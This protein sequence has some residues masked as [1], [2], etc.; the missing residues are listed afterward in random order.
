MQ[1]RNWNLFSNI[2]TNLIIIILLIGTTLDVTRTQE[3]DPNNHP[4]P[5][6]L[7]SS[8]TNAL[9]VVA[10]KPS[11]PPFIKLALQPPHKSR[12]NPLL[13]INMWEHAYIK[14]FGIKGKEKYIDSFWDC[15]N[16]DTVQR[17]TIQRNSFM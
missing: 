9:E 8:K 7:S 17:R 13:C 15:I 11:P 5:S 10:N 12:F 1:V 16:W 3:K 2:K 14:D 6:F 4:I